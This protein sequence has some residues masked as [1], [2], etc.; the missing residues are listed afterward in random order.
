MPTTTE[1][2]LTKDDVPN[3]KLEEAQKAEAPKNEPERKTTE[4]AA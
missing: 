4:V 2:G 1:Q 3:T